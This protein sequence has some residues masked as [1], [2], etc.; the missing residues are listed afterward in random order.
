[1]AKRKK[2]KRV[3]RSK[4]FSV[5]KKRNK[6]EFDVNIPTG[7]TRS[8][9]LQ[10]IDKYMERYKPNITSIEIKVNVFRSYHGNAKARSFLY[11]LN[12]TDNWDEFYGDFGDAL[13]EIAET[14]YSPKYFSGAR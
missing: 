14:V 3:K 7:F 5:K 6:N 1:M 10:A 9:T 13:D 2:P 8:Q 12:D 11:V 4:R